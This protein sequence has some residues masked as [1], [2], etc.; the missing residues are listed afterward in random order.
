MAGRSRKPS[1][2]TPGRGKQPPRG[3]TNAIAASTVQQSIRVH[4]GKRKALAGAEASA[5]R[6]ERARGTSTIGVRSAVRQVFLDRVVNLF[7][8]LADNASDSVIATALAEPTALGT[9][10]LALAE[11]VVADQPLEEADR[12]I[13]AAL[14]AGAQYKEDLLTRS[15]GAYSAEQLGRLLGISRQAVNDGRKTHL[16]F[17]VPSGQSYAYPKLQLT[18]GGLLPG[19]R[20]FLDAFTLPDAWMKLSVLVEPSER[21]GGRSPLEA[22]RAGDVEGAVMVAATYGGHGA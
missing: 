21:L 9:A 18:E 13:A 3:A 12:Q 6:V 1:A 19:L 20:D 5:Q 4:A 16:Y 11:S 15:G 17:A 14:A 8:E 22:L 2:Q 7:T 10:A